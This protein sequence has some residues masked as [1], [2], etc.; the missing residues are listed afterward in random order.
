MEDKDIKPEFKTKD[1]IFWDKVKEHAEQA[2]N[3]YTDAIRLQKL[4]LKGA[5]TEL[6]AL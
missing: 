4:I 1:Q 3:D 2:I 6:K 5:I